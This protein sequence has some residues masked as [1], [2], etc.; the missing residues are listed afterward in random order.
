MPDTPQ[1]RPKK[2]LYLF[3]AGATHAELADLDATLVEKGRG[4]LIG[5][6]STRVIETARRDPKYRA[7]VEL[8]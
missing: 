3:G 5:D 2:V 4:L 6:V 7:D 1:P 8:V